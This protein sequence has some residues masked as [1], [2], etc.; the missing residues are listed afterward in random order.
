MRMRNIALTAAVVAITALAG[1]ARWSGAQSGAAQSGPPI[2]QIAKL[3]RVS[4]DTLASASTA[5]Q[6]RDGR[7]L[8]NDTRSRRLVLFDSSLAHETVIADTTD[9]TAHAY[10]NFAGTLIHYRGDS[11]LFIDIASLSMVVVDP[12]AKL[13]R[14]MAIPRPDEAQRLLGNVFGVPGFDAHGRLMY[15]TSAGLDGT[16]VLCC[17]ELPPKMSDGTERS[18]PVPKPDTALIVRVDLGSRAADTVT[19]IK[20]EWEKQ[21]LALDDRGYLTSIERVAMPYPM[22]D[23]WAVMAD[24]SLAVVRGRDYH[25][26]WLGA[27]GHWTASSKLP[28]VWKRWDDAQKAAIIDSSTAAQQIIADRMN[29]GRGGGGSAGGGRGGGGGRGVANLR[30]DGGTPIPAV[31]A[32][33]ALAEVPDYERPFGDGAAFPDLDNNLWIRT[34]TIVDGRPVYDIV[35]RRGALIDRAQLP[36]LRSVAGFGPGVIYTAVQDASGKIHLE[37]VRTR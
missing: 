1:G 31:V 23:A 25:V 36:P 27:D 32:R 18:R 37:R 33:A 13:G 2:R 34:T 17:V 7:V 14:I 16:F 11:L 10:G 12:N 15:R 30:R 24:G 4:N 21:R 6:L 8:V 9:A 5:F 22:I 20:I 28:F 26:D 3:E 19:S 29:A 35:N